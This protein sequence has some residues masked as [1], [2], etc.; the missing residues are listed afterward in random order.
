MLLQ[1]GVFAKLSRNMIKFFEDF[2][3]IE[4]AKNAKKYTCLVI[5]NDGETITVLGAD[6]LITRFT[7]H[8]LEPIGTTF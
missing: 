4:N 6:G 7:N 1:V 2:Q 8:D 3:T 5:S